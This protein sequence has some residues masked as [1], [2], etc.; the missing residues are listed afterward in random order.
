MSDGIKITTEEARLLVIGLIHN[1]RDKQRMYN[2]NMR[3]GRQ[4]QKTKKDIEENY[5]NFIA[6]SILLKNK[7][8]L[9]LDNS[10]NS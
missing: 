4:S 9:F 8:K 6:V 5:K 3:D 2:R 7:I 1:E 10:G